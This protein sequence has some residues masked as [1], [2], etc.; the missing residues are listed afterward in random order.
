MTQC[1]R[2]RWDTTR[3][4]LSAILRAIH[5]LGYDAQP[6]D[7]A[8]RRHAIDRERDTL[9]RRIGVAGVLGMQVMTLSAA[10]YFGDW[11]GIDGSYRELLQAGG[12]VVDGT[13]DRL[14]G[15]AFFCRCTKRY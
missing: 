5:E 9:L 6:Y 8:R 10:L 12:F 15:A 13:G 11:L 1:L 2:I 3:L 7:R 14:F 4:K